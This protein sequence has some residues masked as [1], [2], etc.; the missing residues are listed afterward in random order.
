MRKIIT[1]LIFIHGSG[2]AN[3]HGVWIKFNISR[4]FLNASNNIST[5]GSKYSCLTR[6]CSLYSLAIIFFACWGSVF[7]PYR[8][9]FWESLSYHLSHYQNLHLK[10]PMPSYYTLASKKRT[11]NKDISP[12]N[13]LMPHCS[14]RDWLTICYCFLALLLSLSWFVLLLCLCF[15]KIWRAGSGCIMYCFVLVNWIMFKKRLLV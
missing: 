11:F 13:L 7:V 1:I 5:T 8:G 10:Q 2:I 9:F 4:S 15:S 6:K 3:F 12:H 14:P